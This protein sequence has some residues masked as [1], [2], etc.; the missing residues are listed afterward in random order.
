MFCKY[1]QMPPNNNTLN[2]A[3]YMYDT[4]NLQ[5]YDVINEFH[6]SC[7]NEHLNISQWIN[8]TLL[9]SPISP[10]KLNYK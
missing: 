3:K 6:F 2:V 10:P 8:M 4:L 9:E 5:T 1:D 7:S